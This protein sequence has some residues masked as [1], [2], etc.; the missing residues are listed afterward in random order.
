MELTRRL[1]TPKQGARAC[2]RGPSLARNEP[3]R[4]DTGTVFCLMEVAHAALGSADL[5]AVLVVVLRDAELMGRGCLPARP[6]GRLREGR[7]SLTPAARVL[8]RPIRLALDDVAREALRA[9]TDE[10]AGLGER[11]RAS[12]ESSPRCRA[13]ARSSSGPSE[14]ER[15]KVHGLLPPS[16]PAAST[17]GGRTPS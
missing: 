6:R 9:G 17:T 14:P 15:R 1:A 4:P 8:M 16:G 5:A 12:A 3:P 11:V 10:I 2:P 7:P 13:A